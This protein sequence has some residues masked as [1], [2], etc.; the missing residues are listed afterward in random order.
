MRSPTRATADAVLTGDSTIPSAVWRDV[1][2]F[3]DNMRLESAAMS[4][5]TPAPA[6]TAML[7]VPFSHMPARA[8]DRREWTRVHRHLRPVAALCAA[9]CAM[10]GGLAAAGALPRPLQHASASFGSH[11][12]VGMPRAT[13]TPAAPRNVAAPA[14]PSA[15]PASVALSTA[16][17]SGAFLAAPVAP[18]AK[19]PELADLLAANPPVAMSPP[20]ISSFGSGPLP[21]SL[22]R[23]LLPA[24]LDPNDVVPGSVHPV[25]EPDPAPEEPEQPQHERP[26]RHG[27]SR[28]GSRER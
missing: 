28:I 5:P 19:P 17:R 23:D 2:R 26:H 21:L 27:L 3:L 22:P 10:F 8:P 13:R 7:E 9:S 25:T 24:E 15:A 6:L 12:G 11:F 16:A 18:V 20:R 14:P 4:A 1:S